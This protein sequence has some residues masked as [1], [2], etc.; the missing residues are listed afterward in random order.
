MKLIGNMVLLAGPFALL[1]AGCTHRPYGMGGRDWGHM[2]NYGPGGI[3]MWLLIILVVAVVL[4]F[5]FA[6]SRSD[7]FP[8]SRQETPL[9]ILKKRYA[10]GEITREEFEQLKKDLAD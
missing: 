8:P 5:V 9:D 3:F 1:A 2:M 6:R 7:S 4:Y 10:K